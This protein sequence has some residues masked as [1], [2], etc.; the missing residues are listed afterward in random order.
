MNYIK[1]LKEVEILLK[2]IRK[3]ITHYPEGKLL[4]IERDGFVRYVHA[5]Y[6]EGKYV[7]KGISKNV[8]LIRKLARK[9]YLLLM[10][11]ALENEARLIKAFSESYT[12]ISSEDIMACLPV[13]YQDLPEEFFLENSYGIRDADCAS[14]V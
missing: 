4:N 5:Y 8:D 11:E 3:E 13:A 1:R 14:L 10:S 2:D 12:E 7:R 6:D 9:Q